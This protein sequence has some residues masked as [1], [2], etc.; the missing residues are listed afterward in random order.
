LRR[1]AST[2]HLQTLFNL[3]RNHREIWTS[4]VEKPEL[5]RVLRP[6][7]DLAQEPVSEAE[8]LIVVFLILHLAS[9]F[10][11]QRRGMYV[12]EHG[13]RQDVGKFFALPIPAAVWSELKS[14]QSP[15]FVGFVESCRRSPDKR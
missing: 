2:R 11:A 5:V 6:N 3:T 10:E 1:E 4:L 9:S 14:L 8:R 12:P 7:V 13:L 15:D